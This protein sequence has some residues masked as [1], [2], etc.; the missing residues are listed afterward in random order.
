MLQQPKKKCHLRVFGV[1]RIVMAWCTQNEVRIG[2]FGKVYMARL[3]FDVE[4]SCK[5]P[6]PLKS[7]YQLAGETLSLSSAWE[8]AKQNEL[9]V[10]TLRCGPLPVPVSHATR[11]LFFSLLPHALE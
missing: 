3:M 7:C 1:D 9:A 5:G 11:V 8:P 4:Y 2:E 6:A 10:A